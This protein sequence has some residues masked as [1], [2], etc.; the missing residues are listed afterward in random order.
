MTKSALR[1]RFGAAAAAV[2]ATI[3]LAAA[4]A[5]AAPAST[6][7]PAAPWAGEA[8]APGAASGT[9][10]SLARDPGRAADLRGSGDTEIP[11]GQKT[12]PPAGF[13][14]TIPV[15]VHVVHDGSAGLLSRAQV[16]AQ[17]AVLNRTFSGGGGAPDTGF[18]FALAGLDYTDDA[19]WFAQETLAAERAMK[20][21]LRRGDATALN[22][23]TVGFT[24]DLL[25]Y[26]YYPKDGIRRKLQVLDGVVVDYRSLPG[27]SIAGYDLGYTATHEVGHFLGLA[28]T[29]EQGC[30]GHGDYVDDTPPEAIPT[31][32]C[33][34]GKDTCPGDGLDPIHNYMDYSTDACYTGFTAGQV[35][36][37]RQQYLFWREKHGFH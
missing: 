26:A 30:K 12:A 6:A 5:T 17:I 10:R 31:S 7:L 35:V 33:P 1:S 14:T 13:T 25:G 37:M 16:D 34:L 29:F 9:A 11:A 20:A 19:E 23:Y 27:G 32:G 15:Y 36:R 28:H 3:L 8:C 21:A 2:L 18:R 24:S 22:L 4:M